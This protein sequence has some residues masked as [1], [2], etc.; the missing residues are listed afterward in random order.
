MQH[1]SPEKRQFTLSFCCRQDEVSR[2]QLPSVALQMKTGCDW[3]ARITP[4]FKLGSGEPEQS[5]SVAC[6]ALGVFY[7]TS[8]SSCEEQILL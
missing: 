1:F 2:L 4:L 8:S 3:A 5:G 6:R 7:K